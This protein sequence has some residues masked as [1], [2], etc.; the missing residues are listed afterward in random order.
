MLVDTYNEAIVTCKY[1]S[2]KSDDL[3]IADNE[4]KEEM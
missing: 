4:E 3:I 1:T 2:S